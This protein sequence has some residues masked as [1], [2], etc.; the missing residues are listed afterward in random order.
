MGGKRFLSAE[1]SAD[2]SVAPALALGLVALATA[3]F[4]A[5]LIG[6]APIDRSSVVVELFDRLPLLNFESGLS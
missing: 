6:P 4:A 1:V 2:K 5:L 3:V